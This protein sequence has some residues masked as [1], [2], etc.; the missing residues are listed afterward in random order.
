MKLDILELPFQQEKLRF[1]IEDS[2]C[3]IAYLGRACTS[4]EQLKECLPG[5]FDPPHAALLAMACNFLYGGLNFTVIQDIAGFKEKY[6]ERI[7]QEA[8]G[9]ALEGFF[10]L[11]YGHF[12]LSEMRPAAATGDQLIFYVESSSFGIPYKATCILPAS[13]KQA[14]CTY[15]LLPHIRQ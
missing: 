6:E 15:F 10:L 12:D 4:L 5:L 14:G 1:L 9:K 2:V 3:A 8:A 7:Q 13:G 11:Q